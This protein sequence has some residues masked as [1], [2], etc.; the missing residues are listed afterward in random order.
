MA[1][2]KIEIIASVETYKNLS[3]F[4]SIDTLNE[5]VR[6]YIERF[7]DQLN[8]THIAVLKVLHGH[9]AKHL[10]VS[11]LTKRNI[12]K[13]IGKSRATIIRACN[14]LEDLG[15]IKQLEMK[16]SSDMK[17]TSN[18]VIIQPIQKEEPAQEVN[19]TEENATQESPKMQHQ[20]NKI[21]LKQIH[22]IKHLNMSKAASKNKA[23][24]K[25]VPKRLQQYQAFFGNQIKSLYGRIWLAMKN[26]EVRIEQ[27][28]MQEIAHIAFDKIVDYIKQGRNLSTEE[29][30]KLA[31]TIAYNQ[32]SERKDTREIVKD[33]RAITRALALLGKSNQ[34]YKAPSI[35]LFKSVLNS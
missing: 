16:R 20:E 31:Y 17:Q 34:C 11:F 27:S 3:S 10:G 28:I 23:Y 9:S 8:K 5:A 7:N 2:E 6:A 14:H 24:I 13:L 26:L 18:A 33:Q 12:G 21:F 19:Q 30:H 22:N 25:M 32:L 15:I 1:K 29:M 35:D 4:E